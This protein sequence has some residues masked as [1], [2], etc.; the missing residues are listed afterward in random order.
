MGTPAEGSQGD[1]ARNT[2]H[3]GCPRLERW[4]K[5]K[6]NKIDGYPK[7]RPLLTG[8][9]LSRGDLCETTPDE[10]QYPDQGQP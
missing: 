8:G 9:S 5:R 10:E 3:S 2:Q 4:M 1:A 7:N 6:R